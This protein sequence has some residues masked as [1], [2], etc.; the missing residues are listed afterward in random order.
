[1]NSC[2]GENCYATYPHLSRHN[3]RMCPAVNN[4]VISIEIATLGIG[5]MN[6]ENAICLFHAFPV[7]DR[8]KEL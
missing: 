6:G 2:T 7:R 3:P 8:Q 5:G 1:M 4:P